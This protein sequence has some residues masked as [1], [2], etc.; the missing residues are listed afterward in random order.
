MV[1]FQTAATAMSAMEEENKASLSTG[2]VR[3]DGRFANRVQN[4]VEV[5]EFLQ[6][7]YVRLRQVDPLFQMGDKN[8]NVMSADAIP[9]TF[10][11]CVEKFN[12]QIINKRDHQHLMFVV[13][14][15]STKT[16]SVLK[17]A[18]MHLLSRNHLFMNR[19][20]LSASILDVGTVGFILGA[21]PRYHS[22][23]QQKEL[24]MKTINSWW[25]SME[26]DEQA[27]WNGKI[28]KNDEGLQVPPFFIS[29]RSIKGQNSAGIIAHESAFIIMAPSKHLYLLMDV[30]QAVFE[31]IED[32][33]EPPIQFIPTRLQ[34]ADQDTYFQL[35]RQQGQYLSAFQN[36]GI[37]GMHRDVMN[38][39]IQLQDPKGSHVT[40][41]VEKALLLHPAIH[42]VD[43]GA[44]AIPLGKWNISTDHTQAEAAKE[45]IDQVIQSI[46]GWNS[47]N[48]GFK[49]F[50]KITRMQAR[51]KRATGKYAAI[52][53]K[54]TPPAPGNLQNGPSSS[55]N[56]IRQFSENPQEPDIHPLGRFRRT[57]IGTPNSYAQA[58]ARP[59]HTQDTSRTTTS[60]M[61]SSISQ[62]HHIRGVEKEM[63]SMAAQ[64]QAFQKSITANMD[65]MSAILAS[66]QRPQDGNPMEPGF[67]DAEATSKSTNEPSELQLILR[68]MSSNHHTSQARFDSM[69]DTT[70]TRF[71]A[72]DSQHQAVASHVQAITKKVDNL[73]KSN[74]QLQESHSEIMERLQQLEGTSPSTIRS[75][76]RKKRTDHDDCLSEDE[77]MTE[78]S[79]NQSGDS[80]GLRPARNN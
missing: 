78:I 4:P 49:D 19:H 3:F 71:D 14:F 77:D 34:K 52:W 50:P 29:A 16:L 62:D 43:P 12:M 21:H 57:P 79:N 7:L 1:T 11:G 37:A 44:Y 9:A 35:I 48:T 75:P 80:S 39:E 66:Q 42:R 46:P 2:L 15:S 61:I 68:Q 58:A 20:A 32:P 13:S 36:V 31:P 63:Q 74:T 41:T 5:P 73:T 25:D 72:L 10:N 51:P 38:S 69:E 6:K 59:T 53:K 27:K 33:Q 55:N 56:S 60:T 17:K 65:K 26:L 24:M 67:D 18:S 54:V 28:F 47:N 23:S 64:Q 70:Q 22:P 45:W 8:G 76:V 40:T 30:L